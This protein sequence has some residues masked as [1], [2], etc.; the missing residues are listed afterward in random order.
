MEIDKIKEIETRIGYSFT[1]KDIL[2]QAI[3]TK[4]FAKEENDHKRPCKS[5]EDFR[6]H[7]DAILKEVL[8]DLLKEY[9][10]ETPQQIT[11]TKSQLENGVKLAEIFSA[12]KILPDHFQKR[13][14]EGISLPLCAET[15]E[16]L[17]YA[18][19]FDMSTTTNEGNAKKEIKRYITRLFE[20]HINNLKQ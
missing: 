7:G 14:G 4:S 1:N 10:Y 12:F 9:G 17:I 13:S 18:I 3:T 19:Y 16:S 5:Q 8:I 20:P 2:I 11:E 6:T 15:F